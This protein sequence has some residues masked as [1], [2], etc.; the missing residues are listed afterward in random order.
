MKIEILPL[1]LF[2]FALSGLW[3][4]FASSF[5]NIQYLKKYSEMYFSPNRLAWRYPD[6]ATIE[7]VWMIIPLTDYTK[8][9][10]MCIEMFQFYILIFVLWAL[11]FPTTLTL[12]I[13]S[14]PAHV[15]LLIISNKPHI[16][17]QQKCCCCCMNLLIFMLL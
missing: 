1:S 12:S 17:E 14:L 16:Y 13:T 9:L 8:K 3:G 4:E 5:N 11:N 6:I 7:I 10:C 15:S 2:H